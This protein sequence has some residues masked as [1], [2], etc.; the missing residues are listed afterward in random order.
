M[1]QV[2]SVCRHSARAEI[3]LLLVRNAAS[4]RSIAHRYSVTYWSVRR[5]ERN[6]LR[7]TV[8]ASKELQAKLSAENLLRKLSELDATTLLAIAASLMA[9]TLGVASDVAQWVGFGV[10]LV[11]AAVI[12]YFME[13][14]RP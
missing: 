4:L 10:L 1:P 5:H 14:R 12:V 7:T 9:V 11:C 6:C 8:Q 2:C 3:H 13:F